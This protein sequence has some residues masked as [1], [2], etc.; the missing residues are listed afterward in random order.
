MNK[1]R[2]EVEDVQGE[3]TACTVIQGSVRENL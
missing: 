3:V 1:F 2:I